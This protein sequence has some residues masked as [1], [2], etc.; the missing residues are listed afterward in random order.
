MPL[1]LLV[2]FILILLNAFFA[3]SE[4][5]LLSVNETKMKKMAEKGNKKARYVVKFLENSS[6]FLSTIQVG[7][8]FSGF[9]SS[10]VAA[11]SFATRIVE[12]VKA[13]NAS[14]AI[15]NVSRTAS[16]I[17]ITFILSY[18]TLVFGELVPK[19]IA[20]NKS[21]KL[22]LFVIGPLRA[23][24][25]VFSPFIK[26]LTWPVIGV[27]RL[28][29]INP[30][31]EE[32]EVTEEEILLLVNEGQEQGVIGDEESTMISN[33]LLWNDKT[34]SDI[35]THRTEV[36]GIRAD[37][38]YETVMKIVTNARF[39]RFPVY[40]DR[41]D[42]IVGV[43]HIKDLLNIKNESEF[44]LVKLMRAPCFVPES[45]RIDEVFKTLKNTKNHM[46]IVVDEYGGTAGI[47]TMEDI[48]EELVGNIMDEY[49]DEEEAEYDRQIVAIGDNS[50][51]IEGLTELDVVNEEFNINLPV[52]EYDTISGFVIG[53]LGSIPDENTHPSFE[54]EGL[55]FTVEGNNEKRITLVKMEFIEDTA[56]DDFKQEDF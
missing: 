3:A 19:R 27:L 49:D 38:S 4:I 53:N 32:E 20:M 6:K 30:N 41:I 42:N 8:T 46:A 44:D 29:N 34:A 33:V 16:V 7:V 9:L 45:Q 22:A 52:E 21:E 18:F 15:V 24:A 37:S 54:Y 12:F 36:V 25:F 5:A 11:D 39:S 31:N 13:Q 40:E 48:L 1:Q 56:Y 17:I 55:R 23:T 50:Y 47:A 10:A 2:I 35:M 14:P 51:I 43:I 28:F 26:I